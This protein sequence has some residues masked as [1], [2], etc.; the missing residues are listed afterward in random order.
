MTRSSTPGS[1]SSSVLFAILAS[2]LAACAS[3]SGGAGAPGTSTGALE[4]ATLAGEHRVDVRSVPDPIPLNELF[5][6]EVGVY[7]SEGAGTPVQGA[8]IYVRAWMPDHGHGMNRKPRVLP[9]VGGT[10]RVEGML[11]H[12]SGD[13]QIG[14][15]VICAGVASSATFRV[16]MP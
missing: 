4:A 3:S 9:V 5:T 1:R 14:I 2:A 12:M 10:F 13:W 11:F 15:D 16:S 8:Q 7:E 6:L